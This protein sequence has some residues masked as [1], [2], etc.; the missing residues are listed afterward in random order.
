MHNHVQTEFLFHWKNSEE[1]ICCTALLTAEV[2]REQK[3]ILWEQ[4]APATHVVQ[5]TT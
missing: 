5:K 2:H 3:K 1:S 4:K